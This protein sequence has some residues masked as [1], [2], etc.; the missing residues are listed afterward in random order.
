M[1][2]VTITNVPST[3]VEKFSR[4]QKMKISYW[5]FMK[6]H[7]EDCWIDFD[8]NMKIDDFIKEIEKSDD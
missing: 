4:S 5:D 7:E 8:V 1:A 2:D 6:H 3:I